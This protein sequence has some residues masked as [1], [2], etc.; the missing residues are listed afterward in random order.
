MPQF[1]QMTQKFRTEPHMKTARP[2]AGRGAI[3]NPERSADDQLLELQSLVFQ[4]GET[5]IHHVAD[6]HH[7]DH[8]AL[9]D[10]R[11]GVNVGWQSRSGSNDDKP[12]RYSILSQQLRPTERPRLVSCWRRQWFVRRSRQMCLSFLGHCRR[13]RSCSLL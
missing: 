4:R 2:R 10:H 9:F 5:E 13:A 1:I 7:A 8:R 12:P 6:R 11:H 3:G